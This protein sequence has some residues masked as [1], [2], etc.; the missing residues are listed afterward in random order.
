MIFKNRRWGS[1]ASGFGST[2]EQ[3]R[4]FNNR[5][6]Y[7]P[8]EQGGTA[9]VFSLV[10]QLLGNPQQFHPIRGVDHLLDGRVVQHQEDK[11]RDWRFFLRYMLRTGQHTWSPVQIY[12][13]IPITYPLFKY[14][15]IL[16]VCQP[17]T[18]WKYAIIFIR[19]ASE[20]DN[21]CTLEEYSSIACWFLTIDNLILASA[22]QVDKQHRCWN[23][24][25]MDN[26]SWV[27][28]DTDPSSLATLSFESSHLGHWVPIIKTEQ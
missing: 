17:L 2:A 8:V 9:S 26:W 10:M 21:Y 15:T 1:P 25:H 3:I 16:S 4:I 28:M 19:T 13:I 22:F 6:T 14:P 27:R 12:T 24:C 20:H 23:R 18:F 7:S 5:K 11:P